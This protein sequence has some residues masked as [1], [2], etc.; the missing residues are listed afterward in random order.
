[1]GCQPFESKVLST[2]WLSTSNLHLY[3]KALTPLGEHL[4]A[5]PVDARV[6]K[7]LV[8]GAILGKAVQVDIML[9]LG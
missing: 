5:L 3:T 7:A 4:A 9:T 6:G 2:F 8:Y 1:M